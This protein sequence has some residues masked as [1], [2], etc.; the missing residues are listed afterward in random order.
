METE[1]DSELEAAAKD[2]FQTGET[3]SG[4]SGETGSVEPESP[5]SETITPP[6]SSDSVDE[7]WA[8][9]DGFKLTKDQARSYAELEAYLYANPDKAKILSEALSGG[10]SQPTQPQGS[11]ESTSPTEI[12]IDE[13]TSP[14]VRQLY[15]AYQATQQELKTL[16]GTTSNVE[17]YVATQQEQTANSLM[18]RATVSFKEQF[19]VSDEELD[20]L[21]GVAARLNVLPSLMSPVDPIT[22][23]ARRVDPLAAIEEA[24]TIAYWQIPEFRTRAISSEVD[25]HNKDR[26]RKAR[27]SSLQGSS[28]SIP[29]ENPTPTT[30]DERR[31]AMIAEVAGYLGREK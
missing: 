23:Q 13:F 8:W 15:E 4:D 10:E 2:I 6:E 30:Q 31:T 28:G 18:N 27:I 17:S 20:S 19:K 21:K 26:A 3:G 29:R 16:Q 22:G 11:P 25:S 5:E 1:L 12:S 7:L 9:D 24:L 14:E